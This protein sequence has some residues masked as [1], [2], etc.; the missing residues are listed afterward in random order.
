MIKI[1]AKYIVMFS[2]FS[3]EKPEETVKKV[4]EEIVDASAPEETPASA[5]EETAA[6]APE[7][8]PAKVEEVTKAEDVVVVDKQ[9][10][11]LDK[12]TPGFSCTIM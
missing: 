9:S 5:P 10:S 8:T 1:F 2:Y 11:A 6:S 12:C 7:E 4:V 3:E